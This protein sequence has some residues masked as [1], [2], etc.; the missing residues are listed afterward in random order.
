[1]SVLIWENRNRLA[2][3]FSE[4]YLKYQGRTGLGG[5]PGPVKGL[6]LLEEC[7]VLCQC[8]SQAPPPLTPVDTHVPK[9]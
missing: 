6:L 2:L 9:I 3:Y 1:M 7:L 5:S 8:Q 4:K